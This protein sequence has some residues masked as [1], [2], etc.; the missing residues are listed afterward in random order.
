[1]EEIKGTSNRVLEVDLRTQ[2]TEIYEITSEE[3]MHYIGG[4]GLGLK[5]FYDRVE[6]GIDPLSADNIIAIMPGIIMGT[7]A[8]NSG[9]FDAVTKSPL[10]GIMTTSSCGGPFGIHLKTAGW[11]GL[12]IKGIAKEPTYLTLDKDGVKF[13]KA[14]KLWGKSAIIAQKE[15]SDNKSGALVIGPAGEKGVLFANV[16]SGE[17]FLGRGGMGAVFGSK[18]LKAII[19]KGKFYKI[20]P[21]DQKGFDKIKK[22]AAK[23]IKT[24]YMTS[25]VY[26]KYGT[27]ANLNGSNAANILPIR[28]FKDGQHEDAYKLSG[29]AMS[30]KHSTK[31]HVCKPCSILCGKKGTFE[32]E[33]LPVPEFETIGLMGTNLEIFDSNYI[34]KWNWLCSNLA[35]D[36]IST[37]AVLG[38]VMEAAEKGLIKSNLKF[39]STEGVED[40]LNEMVEGKTELGRDMAKGTRF[41]SNKYGG[42]DFAIQVKGLEMAAYEPRGAYGQG[43]NYATANRGACH[44]SSYPIALEIYFNLINPFATYGKAHFVKFQEDLTCLVNSVH[45][46]QFTMFA[47]VFESLLTKMTPK[48][49]LSALM[50]YLPAIATKLIDYSVYQKLW[51]T[52]SGMKM[53]S[54]AFI[55]AG[56]RIHV[57]ER[58]MNTLEGISKKDDTLPDR[59]LNEGRTSDP[60]Q[61]VVP[62]EKMLSKY[63]KLRKFDENG[64]P[65]DELLKKL[66][67]EKKA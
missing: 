41:L 3:R 45:T 33:T 24:N 62:L 58:Y 36:T 39:G 52:I 63:Y 53:S 31:H 23:N 30:N 44:L 12:L 19:A 14:D 56:E 32:G 51:Q 17:R 50:S 43:L 4:K 18:N 64:I 61:R 66:S 57:L 16:I 8:P 55:K 35:M 26:T 60:L 5:L 67:I 6:P 29:E 28:N 22:R 40:A 34:A 27:N 49:I 15:I 47:Y 46:C 59:M 25:D 7:S 42:K 54:A 37:G 2:K 10:T 38:W 9:R 65:T 13:H 48:P 11:D 1:M 21:V 20:V